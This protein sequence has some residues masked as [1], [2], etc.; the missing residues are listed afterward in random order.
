MPMY[1]RRCDVCEHIEKDVLERISAP[2]YPC[3]QDLCDGVMLRTWLPGAANGVVDDSIP[4]GLEIKNA[5]CH[6]D[7]SPRRF[8]SKSD[9]AR[10][11]KRLGWTNAVEHIGLK[12]SDKSPHTVKWASAPLMGKAEDERRA[13]WHEHE[14]TLAASSPIS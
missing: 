1:D 14:K 4:G 5:L 8:D 12:G 2:D 10:E 11:A 9:I 3:D 7:G 6:P 13:A